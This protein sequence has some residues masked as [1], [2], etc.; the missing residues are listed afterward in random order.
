MQVEWTA[1]LSIKLIFITS[2]SQVIE[3]N[4]LVGVALRGSTRNFWKI[5]GSS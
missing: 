4:E 1:L 2:V 5:E 3:S